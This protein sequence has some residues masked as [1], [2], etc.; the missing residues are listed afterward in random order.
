MNVQSAPLALQGRAQP[1]LAAAG[2][3]TDPRRHVHLVGVRL[4]DHLAHLCDDIAGA[5][6]EAAAA[7]PQSA[8]QV[9]Q[10]VREERHPV[11][12]REARIGDGVV[13]YEQGHERGR[14][15][16]RRA[17]RWMVVQAQI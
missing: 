14:A 15:V 6:H 9:R 11:G 2:V 12:C 17:Q 4:R 8:V 13:A 7:C 3:A 5:H 10:T 16:L 1:L